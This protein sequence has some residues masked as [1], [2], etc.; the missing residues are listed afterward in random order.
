MVREEGG[1]GFGIKRTE[2]GRP[3]TAV[4]WRIPPPMGAGAGPPPP[5]LNSSSSPPAAGFAKGRRTSSEARKKKNSIT[6]HG[7]DMRKERS[8]VRASGMQARRF[9]RVIPPPPP[10]MKMWR[11]NLRRDHRRRPS[12]R[13]T[14]ARDVPTRRREEA[15]FLKK[16][17]YQRWN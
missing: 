6:D 2:G 7:L 5:K 15:C 12:W 10:C 13:K 17:L 11:C 8:D 3:G 4:G 14:S 1:G 16:F 9:H